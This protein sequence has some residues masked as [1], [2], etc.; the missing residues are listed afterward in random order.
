MLDT[1]TPQPHTQQPISSLSAENLS[2]HCGG[3][4][5]K[6]L[7]IE[8]FVKSIRRHSQDG[9][10]PLAWQPKREDDL[11]SE[12][13]EILAT[14]LESVES[15]LQDALDEED[16]LQDQLELETDAALA[17]AIQEEETWRKEL[18]REENACVPEVDLE[19][20][21]ATTEGGSDLA[22]GCIV[23]LTIDY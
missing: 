5:D 23:R 18:E 7:A 14:R 13:D 12:E 21:V 3:V 11:S 6:N 20:G 10:I 8:A 22:V 15:A 1:L 4:N 17:S 9:G 19:E 2:K 16:Q